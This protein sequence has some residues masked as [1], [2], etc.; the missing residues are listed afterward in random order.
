MLLDNFFF[1]VQILYM[2][3]TFISQWKRRVRMILYGRTKTFLGSL[4]D[5]W[6]LVFPI[7]SH[8]LYFHYFQGE[9]SV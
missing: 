4:G 3:K 2:T 6:Q 7:E 5:I 8:M 1:F 9:L